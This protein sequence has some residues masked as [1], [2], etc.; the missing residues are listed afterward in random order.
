MS[1]AAPFAD[2]I[3]MTTSNFPQ[4]VGLKRLH[5]GPKRLLGAAGAAM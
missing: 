3:V 4:L 5:A 1:H 2:E